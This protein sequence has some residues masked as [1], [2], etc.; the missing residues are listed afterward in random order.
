M[1]S[2]GQVTTTDPFAQPQ[3]VAPVATPAPAPAA[4]TTQQTTQQAQQPHPQNNNQSQQLAEYKQQQHDSEMDA[5]QNK[6]GS[7]Q[8]AADQTSDQIDNV[9]AGIVDNNNKFATDS[10][11][12]AAQGQQIANS[13]EQLAYAQQKHQELVAKAMDSASN[14][15]ELRWRYA[16]DTAK[17]MFLSKRDILERVQ[18]A[19]EDCCSRFIK[20][21]NDMGRAIS[22]NGGQSYAPSGRSV[23]PMAGEQPSDASARQYAMNAN[24]MQ[25]A[26]NESAINLNAQGEQI[27]GQQQQQASAA[28][29]LDRQHDNQ[30]KSLHGQLARLEET[31]E[32]YNEHVEE[33]AAKIEE[34]AAEFASA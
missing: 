34:S 30:D 21:M 24:D 4:T 16:M 19:W 26:V 6:Q 20:S 14:A 11:Q 15:Q 27:A 13:R 10:Q 28:A 9:Q 33:T 5:L 17:W 12:L 1:W 32:R 31:L 3:S 25:H 2:G 7:Y 22:G 23:Q 29:N 18:S 8:D